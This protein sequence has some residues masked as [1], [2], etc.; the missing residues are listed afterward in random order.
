MTPR[1]LNKVCAHPVAVSWVVGAFALDVAILGLLSNEVT[2]TAIAF[3]WQ[4]ALFLVLGLIP[5]T[6]LGY[7]VGMFTCWPFIR[8]ICSKVNGAPFEAGDHVMILSGPMKGSTA[9]V[10]EITVSQGGWDVVWLDL[11]PERRKKF[12]NIFEEYSLLKIN[13][14]RGA[15]S[16]NC[17][18]SQLPASSESHSPDSHRT[19]S[20][21]GGG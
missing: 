4:A 6:L 16:N 18:P 1:T 20:S 7:F 14:E 8:P 12:S 11:G 2:L 21:G 3:D 15:A 19:A 13:C 17:S 10:E 5:A 9:E